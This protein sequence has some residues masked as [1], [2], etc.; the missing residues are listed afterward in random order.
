MCHIMKPLSEYSPCKTGKY[1]V[2]NYCK[3]CRN[4]KIYDS[5]PNREMIDFKRGLKAQGLKRCASCKEVKVLDDFYKDPKHVDGRYS[6]CKECFNHKAD[7]RY[8]RRE[9]GIGLEDYYKL[10]ESQDGLCAICGR[11]PKNNRFN[12]DHDHKTHEIRALLCVNCN[13]N[14]LPYVER[15]PV[16][17]KNAFSYLENPPAFLVIG[18]KQVPTTNQA[19]IKSE[20]K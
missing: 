15:F 19:R 7:E 12:V 4:S 13:T 10:L 14:L 17:V 18:R 8:L 6:Y 5:Q 11:A 16:W 20:N 9:Y 2:Y 3:T 1:G